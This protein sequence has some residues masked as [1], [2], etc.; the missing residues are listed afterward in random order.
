MPGIMFAVFSCL[1]ERIFLIRA[2]SGSLG[3][4]FPRFL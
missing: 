1:R 4:F 3:S 2:P